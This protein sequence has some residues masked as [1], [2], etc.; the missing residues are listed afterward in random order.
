M[1][2]Q[3]PAAFPRHSGP[4]IVNAI[5]KGDNAAAAAALNRFCE[6]YRPAILNFFRRRSS[7]LEQAEDFAQEFFLTKVH[8]LWEDR[9]R[10][11]LQRPAGQ[12][13][14]VS[15]LPGHSSSFFSDRP[16]EKEDVAGPGIS[17]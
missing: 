16:V 7:T 13:Q 3:I 1:T 12:N 17:G 2:R 15:L 14:T 5:Q 6:K 10:I 8:K 4:V 9:F 11:S